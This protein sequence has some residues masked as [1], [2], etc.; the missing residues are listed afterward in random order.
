MQLSCWSVAEIALSAQSR[1]IKL[2]VKL[3]DPVYTHY[4]ISPWHQAGS[5][6]YL[7]AALLRLIPYDLISQV[8]SLSLGLY[9]LQTYSHFLCGV[10]N[11]LAII[12]ARSK[13]YTEAPDLIDVLIMYS[14][15]ESCE[16]VSLEI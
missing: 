3:M 11:N 10:S 14:Q 6:V 9:L 12:D 8:L 1:W 16:L 13:C 7:F 5:L 2:T 15:F 4:W